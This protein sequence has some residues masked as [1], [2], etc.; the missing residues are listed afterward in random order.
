MNVACCCRLRRELCCV[1]RQIAFVGIVTTDTEVCLAGNSELIAPATPRIGIRVGI[2]ATRQIKVLSIRI[3][4]SPCTSCSFERPNQSSIIHRCDGATGYSLRSIITLALRCRRKHIVITSVFI[5]DDNF[6]SSLQ[7]TQVFHLF[8]VGR[9]T[10]INGFQ[11]FVSG[12]IIHFAFQEQAFGQSG[13]VCC[14]S[15]AALRPARKFP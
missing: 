15:R 6:L 9:F 3:F 10:A 7:R 12:R 2:I 14:Q 13:R 1:S 5:R 11:R 4:E 8:P